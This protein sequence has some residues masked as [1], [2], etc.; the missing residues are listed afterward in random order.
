MIYPRIIKDTI[1]T[2]IEQLNKFKNQ[3]WQIDVIEFIMKQRGEILILSALSLF[4]ASLQSQ[5]KNTKYH[6]TIHF[7]P[8]SISYISYTVSLTTNI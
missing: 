3:L 5:F 8:K 6:A 4:V 1:I 7:R 2:M